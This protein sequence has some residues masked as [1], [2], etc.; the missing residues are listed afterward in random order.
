[1]LPKYVQCWGRAHIHTFTGK[2]AVS[3][4]S[5]SMITIFYDLFSLV[6]YV[7]TGCLFSVK[8]NSD[9][10]NQKGD[11]EKREREKTNHIH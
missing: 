11:K 2:P 1:M 4:I 5:C 6:F 8:Y 9:K 10:N 7:N 3:N